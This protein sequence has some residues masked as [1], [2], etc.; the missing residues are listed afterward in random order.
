MIKNGLISKKKVVVDNTL[1]G[2]MKSDIFLRTAFNF[3]TNSVAEAKK[4]GFT[5]KNDMDFTVFEL[6]EKLKNT[7]NC[8]KCGVELNYDDQKNTLDAHLA[9]IIPISDGGKLK[10]D[11]LR[12][13]CAAC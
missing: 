11:N 8:Q 5:D 4:F 3:I 2:K 1:A 12:V 10:K 13:V 9:H 6:A 7:K